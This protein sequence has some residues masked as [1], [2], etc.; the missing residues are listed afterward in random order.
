MKSI[1][2]FLNIDLVEELLRR[3]GLDSKEI[4]GLME[5]IDFF[6]EEASQ[7]DHI[8]KDY[9]GDE[10]VSAVID[11]LYREI[12]RVGVK[13]PYILDVG[14]GSGFFTNIVKLRLRESGFKPY[15]Y[16]LDISPGMLSE[17]EKKGITPIWGVAD[18]ISESIFL[19]NEYFDTQI[20]LRY[21]IVISTL[22]LHHFHS[23]RDVLRS[24]RS[25]LRESGEVII[26]DVLKHGYEDL[27]EKLKDVHLGFDVE[28]IRNLAREIFPVVDVDILDGV[29]CRVDDTEVGLFKALMKL[30]K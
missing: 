25:V 3:L 29:Y 21:D 17:L 26:L 6:E 5:Q 11:E 15:I 16:G 18:K 27:H 19:N 28:E 1:S 12:S 20:P 24:M 9:F 7:R 13:Y 14:A 2:G 10:C 30:R 23:P 4:G 8:V 22:A